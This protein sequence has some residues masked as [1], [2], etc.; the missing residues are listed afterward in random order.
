M[1]YA[2]QN[3]IFVHNFLYIML[4]SIY[5][6]NYAIIEEININFYPHF[7][8]ITGETG[9]GKSIL[10]GALGL[11][12]GKRADSN[13]LRNKEVKCIIETVFDISTH[14]LQ[15]FFTSYD[16]D[17]NHACIIR[18][19]INPNGKSRAFIN[20]TPVNLEILQQ[21]TASL[22]D[23][24]AQG[25]VQKLLDDFYFCTILDQIAK[26]ADR[27][28]SYEQQFNH[29]KNLQKK[30]NQLQ[31]EKLQQQ[32]EYDYN[33]FILNEFDNLN[34][35]ANY[36]EQLEQDIALQENAELI[37][38]NLNEIEQV[39]DNHELSILTQLIQINKLLQPIAT[40]NDVFGEMQQQVLQAIDDFKSMQ[41][42]LKQNVDAIEYQPT[43]LQEIQDIFNVFNKLMQKHQVNSI[44][45]LI[46]IKNNFQTK[47]QA[48]SIN[49]V[50]IDALENEIQKLENKL[51]VEAKE[52]SNNRKACIAEFDKNLSNILKNIGMPFAK[53]ELKQTTTTLNSKGIDKIELYFSPNKGVETKPLQQVGSGGE[54]SRLML[55]IKSLTAETKSLPTLIFDEIDTGISGEVANKVADLLRNI[56]KSH[57]VVAITH[58]PQVAAKAAH[59]FFV[60]KNHD[61]EMTYTNIKYLNKDER[62]HEI[63][64][65]LSGENPTN[66]AIQNA[67]NIML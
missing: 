1:L 44:V 14:Q 54:K 32:K 47:I 40:I 33:I 3:S 53:T 16:L 67:K 4:Q 50:E 59:H 41:R 38:N 36:Y 35:D 9:A 27:V 20:D 17:Y 55:A 58:L 7:N 43:K 52:I 45:E 26:Q 56:A 30:L 63:A 64:V 28:V 48:F 61:K 10:L 37:I 46:E 57:Q 34:L 66:A 15:S 42:Q 25:E 23:V 62:I 51:L 24:H 19:E 8:V 2:K 22:I 5:I 13:V 21:L 11:I 29:Y 60:Y 6:N 12:L 49:A 31:Q 65:M 18:R 39:L